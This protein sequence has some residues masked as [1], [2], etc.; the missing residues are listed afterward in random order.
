MFLAFNFI[1]PMIQQKVAKNIL[2]FFVEL[3]K[4]KQNFSMDCK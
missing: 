4:L 2:A 3:K 1:G